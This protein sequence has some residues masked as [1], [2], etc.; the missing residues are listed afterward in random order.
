[1]T[2]EFVMNLQIMKLQ[3]IL[4]ICNIY[5]SNEVGRCN[6]WQKIAF[7]SEKYERINGRRYMPSRYYIFKS[8][9]D[10]CPRGKARFPFV[11]ST[12]L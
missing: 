1:M 10:N 3:C 4:K 6:Y 2:K 11:S 5:I 8:Q 12:Y 7:I 9:L